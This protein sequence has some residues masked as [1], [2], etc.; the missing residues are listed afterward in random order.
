M[1]LDKEIK[2]NS[3]DDLHQIILNN[4]KM[5]FSEH[6]YFKIINA[7]PI[8]SDVSFHHFEYIIFEKQIDNDKKW[9]YH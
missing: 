7:P 6:S 4:A 1:P 8:Q 2:Q 3:K 5:V 9:F